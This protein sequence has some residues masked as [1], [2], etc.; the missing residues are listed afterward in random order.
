M[1]YTIGEYT[2]EFINPTMLWIF[3]CFALIFIFF[4]IFYKKFSIKEIFILLLNF[5]ILFSLSIIAAEP[6]LLEKNDEKEFN[7][8]LDLSE[9]MNESLAQSLLDNAAKKF[10][11][12][13]IPFSKKFSSVKLGKNF[14]YEKLKKQYADLDFG[15]T[16]LKDA[17]LSSNSQSFLISDGFQNEKSVESILNEIKYPIFPL[18]PTSNFKNLETVKIDK[19]LAPHIVNAGDEI[20]V[21]AAILNSSSKNFL[22]N[23]ELTL[24]EKNLISKNIDIKKEKSN[25]YD[26]NLKELPEG[27]NELILRLKSNSSEANIST[28]K[29]FYISVKEKSKILLLSE[30]NSD[31]RIFKSILNELGYKTDTSLKN[32]SIYK[33]YKAVILNNIH[34][35]NLPSTVLNLLP[36]NTKNGAGML[37]IGG[38]QSFGLG[39]YINSS[40]EKVLPVKLLPPQTKK[41]RLNLAVSLV[42]D[43]SGSMKKSFKLEYAK[44]AAKAVI[45]SLKDEDYF[46]LIGF[47]EA[48]FILVKMG[49]LKKTRALATKK[50]DLLF[51][52]GTTELLPAMNVAKKQLENVPAGRKHMII[53]TD[54][55][56]PH[57]LSMKSYYS[58]LV[59]Q[60]KSTGISVSTFLIGSFEEKLLQAIADQGGGAFH[61]VSDVRTLPKLFLKDI[62]VTTGERTKKESS[63]YKVSIGEAGLNILNIENYPSLLGYVETKRKENTNIELIVKDSQKKD[64]LLASWKYGKGKVIAYTSDV[65]GRWSSKWVSWSKYKKFWSQVISSLVGGGKKGNKKEPKFDLRYKV[66]GTNLNLD[67]S[68]FSDINSDSVSANLI[69]PDG[70]VKTI[71]FTKKAKGKFISLAEQITPGKYVFKGSIGNSKLTAI[72]FYISGENFG[73]I[74]GKGFNLELLNKIANKSGGVI[75]PSLEDI[76]A[77]IKSTFIKTPLSKFLFLLAFIL[78]LLSTLLRKIFS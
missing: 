47:D 44:L 56:I 16:N 30:N 27:I 74:K 3:P 20:K 53:L 57:G 60:M 22:G 64:P 37:M 9:S 45:D 31:N 63:D 26:L 7:V 50:T 62:A 19:I 33:D 14:Q 18:I 46:G 4:N 48:P 17:I 15:K 55:D 77:G 51:A 1:K 10:K 76:K 35:K 39:G 41:K 38:K 21:K 11:I 66:K 8:I 34:K 70:K 29:K 6:F 36:E 72:A 40:I 25:I 12:N 28:Q 43:K 58:K 75:N 54:G 13:L 61:R 59:G 78:F 67:L 52:A 65:N 2:F 32:A 5:G 23:I 68:I 49:L 24:N 42:L 69:Y 73:E 71:Q